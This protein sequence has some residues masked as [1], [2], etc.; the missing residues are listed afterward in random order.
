MYKT[1][2]KMLRLLTFYLIGLVLLLSIGCSDSDDSF[3][4]SD[5]TAEVADPISDDPPADEPTTEDPPRQVNRDITYNKD[6]REIIERKCV[7]C[8]AEG[9]IAPFPL[10]TY[11]SVEQ[12][13]AAAAYAIRAGTMPPWPPTAGYTPFIDNRSLSPEEKFKL[14]YWLENGMLEGDPADAQATVGAT[15]VATEAPNYDL[16]LPMPQPYTPYLQPDDHRCFAIEWPL[17]EFAYVTS[18]D[19]LPGEREVVHHVIVSIAEPE[20]AHLYYGADGEDGR[21]GWYCLGAGG[22][23]G[24]PLPR[25]IGGWVPGAGREPTPAGTGV[26]VEPG[27]V[28]VVQMHYNTL[29]AQ[30]EPD[31]ST[32]LIATAEEVERPARGF[33][34][35]NPGFLNEGGM[36]IPEGDPDVTHSWSVPTSA[37]AAIFGEDAG[38]TSADSW[39]IH[40]GFLHMHNLGT[41]GRVTLQRPDGSEQVLLD[42]R[43]WDFNWQ[44]TYNFVD[45]VLV[46]PEDTITLTCSWDNSQENQEFVNGEQLQTRYVEWGDGTQDEMCLTSVYLTTQLEGKDYS[47][48]PGLHIESPEYLQGFEAGDVVPLELILNNFTLHDPGEHNHEDAANPDDDHA[49]GGDDHSS[50]FE[51]HYHV[52]LNTDDDDAEHLT[53]WDDSYYYELPDNLPPGIHELRVSLRGSDH[54]PLGVEQRVEIE[55]LAAD[56]TPDNQLVDVNSWEYQDADEDSLASHRASEDNCPDNSWYNEDGALEVETGYCS[57]L[58]LSQPSLTGVAAGDVVHLV[59]WHGDLA[60]DEPAEAHVV[61]SLDSQIIWEEQVAIPA[62]ANIFDTRVTVPFDAPAGSKVEYHLHNHGYNTWTL[63]QLE[64]E[65]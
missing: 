25:Q 39:V 17:D 62:E 15:V 37:L 22:V 61:I 18:V 60:F 31:Q 19:V 43:D 58:S 10:D 48:G 28:V 44:G 13:G 56:A 33:L 30:P 63:L 57:Y 5:I 11:H 34:L 27:S 54:H 3:S 42:I 4:T 45:E 8:H 26:G 23:S 59:L 21:P 55:I 20:D 36:P 29:V 32:V 51:G 14:L 65:R 47:H 49:A 41:R 35:T 12:F 9:D 53:A 16:E 40:Q 24:A 38:V 2:A 50:V 52:Y 6:T 1:L 64:V 7:T 46:G